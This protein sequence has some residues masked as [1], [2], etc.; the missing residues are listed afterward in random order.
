MQRT[1]REAENEGNQTAQKQGTQ[2][3]E[4]PTAQQRA[5][6]LP[7]SGRTNNRENTTIEEVEIQ[8]QWATGLPPV[9]QPNRVTNT[10]NVEEQQRASGLPP[11]GH[12]F[13]VPNSNR[14]LPKQQADSRMRMKTK[15]NFGPNSKNKAREQRLFGNENWDPQASTEIDDLLR[16][17]DRNRNIE[18]PYSPT[19]QD[20]PTNVDRDTSPLGERSHNRTEDRRGPTCRSKKKCRFGPYKKNVPT[21]AVGQHQ[22]NQPG[23]LHHDDPPV[24]QF[25]GTLIEIQARANLPEQPRPNPNPLG[26]LIQTPPGLEPIGPSRVTLLPHRIRQGTPFDRYRKTPTT[27]APPTAHPNRFALRRFGMSEE[28][29]EASL[30]AEVDERLRQL[31]AERRL[32]ILTANSAECPRIM[33]REDCRNLFNATGI[34]PPGALEGIYRWVFSESEED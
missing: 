7:P 6:G 23:R 8:H 28:E 9:G 34:P 32:D 13:Q 25:E 31:E 27:L 12:Q 22:R 33:T 1:T 24:F 19:L 15:C 18:L 20:I 14:N 26:P 11:S 30:S 2:D 17:I 10:T 16:E 4:E 3:L 5:S 21:H 29:L